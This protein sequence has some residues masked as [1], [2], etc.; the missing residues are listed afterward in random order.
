MT[1]S[2]LSLN[3]Q[4]SGRISHCEHPDKDM[5]RRLADLG[6]Y[7]GTIVKNVLTSPKNDPI[8]Y[9]LRGTTIALRNCDAQYVKLEEENESGE[10]S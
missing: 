5:R 2:L 1:K 7:Q 4:E 10:E 6:F 8:A 3:S 9:K